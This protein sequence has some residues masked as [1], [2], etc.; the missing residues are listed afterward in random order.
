[1]SHEELAG[2]KCPKCGG[3]PGAWVYC[4]ALDQAAMVQGGE[5]KNHPCRGTLEK[6]AQPVEFAYLDHQSLRQL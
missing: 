6:E 3:C 4:R 1:M 2:F 5:N